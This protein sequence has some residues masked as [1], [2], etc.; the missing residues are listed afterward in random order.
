MILRMMVVGLRAVVHV[1]D[2]GLIV[3]GAGVRCLS[4]GVVTLAGVL[5]MVHGGPRRA[6]GE[7]VWLAMMDLI[8]SGWIG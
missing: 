7:T 2:L 3:V 1:R 8:H 4:V 6:P 5:A